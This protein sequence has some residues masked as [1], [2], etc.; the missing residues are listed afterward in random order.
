MTHLNFKNL[1]SPF[2]ALEI[3]SREVD[4]MKAYNTSM[5]QDLRIVLESEE[6]DTKRIAEVFK[7]EE[8]FDQVQKEVTEFLTELL[9]EPLGVEDV[10]RAK[11]QLKLVDEY[12]SV[13]DYAAQVL[14]LFLR[15]QDQEKIINASQRLG[16]IDL[17]KQ[18]ELLVDL[19]M[20]PTQE[21]LVQILE[22]SDRI[23][24][25]VRRL[26]NAHW[27]LL[28]T[29]KVDPLVSTSYTD[30]LTSYRKMKNHMVQVAEAQMS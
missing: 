9:S 14:K 18:I 24:D 8:M 4:K 20:E 1:E 6:T 13:S 15:L 17:H 19:T 21:K 22:K 5:I 12:E 10:E 7:M 28:S 23:T 2:A 25:E 27:D 16:L 29:E 3:S 11:R 30:I 26:R